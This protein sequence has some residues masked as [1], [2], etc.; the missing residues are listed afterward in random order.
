VHQGVKHDPLAGAQEGGAS[1]GVRPSL[2]HYC[3]AQGMMAVHEPVVAFVQP[4]DKLR[5][6]DGGEFTTLAPVA[7]PAR[8]DEVPNAIGIRHL[9]AFFQNPGQKVID[10]CVRQRRLGLAEEAT[11]PLVAIE[12]RPHACQIHAP[13]AFDEQ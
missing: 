3:L 5:R 8:K 11:P 7:A 13:C 1:L 2:Q 4:R 6:G 9:A 10:V 12:R